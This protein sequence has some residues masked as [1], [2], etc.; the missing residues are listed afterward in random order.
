MLA[1]CQLCHYYYLK[2]IKERYKECNNV[3]LRRRLYILFAL[4]RM[5]YVKRLSH[6]A[7]VLSTGNSSSSRFFCLKVGTDDTQYNSIGLP[8]GIG[9]RNWAVPFGECTPPA[10]L[11]RIAVGHNFKQGQLCGVH[12]IFRSGSPF[13][14]TRVVCGTS[15][16]MN[17]VRLC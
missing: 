10:G 12:R 7:D 13:S 16:E 3:H 8:H 4:L 14:F 17:E 9:N 11:M 6:D 1:R 5:K 15:K 2:E